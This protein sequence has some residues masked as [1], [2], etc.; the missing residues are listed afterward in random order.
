MARS[1]P[2]T[3]EEKQIEGL[4]LCAAWS[5]FESLLGDRAWG[6]ILD[7][8]GPWTEGLFDAW[9]AADPKITGEAA[10]VRIWRGSAFVRWN[11][12]EIRAD[13]RFDGEWSAL[14][15]DEADALRDGCRPLELSDFPKAGEY[16]PLP[17][18]RGSKKNPAI[19]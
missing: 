5:P 11:P 14:S 4:A 7:L 1:R 19:A 12:I 9:C 16:V 2:D 13:V 15:G 10:G 17:F 8:R 3:G 6:A 18:R